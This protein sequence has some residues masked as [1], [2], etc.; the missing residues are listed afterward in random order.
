MMNIGRL[1]GF[2]STVVMVL[3]SISSATAPEAA[4]IAMNK[5]VRNSVDNPNS[6]KSLLSSLRVYIVSDGH[7]KSKKRAATMITR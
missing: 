1:T 4:N 5:L 7:I 2:E 3:F 6:R